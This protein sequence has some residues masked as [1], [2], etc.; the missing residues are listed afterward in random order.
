[1]SEIDLEKIKHVH[2][3]GIGGIGVSALARMFVHEGK[4][5]SGSDAAESKVTRDLEK[6]GVKVTIG[7][8]KENV[9]ADVDLVVYSPAVPPTNPEL[10]VAEE[11]GVQTLSY[12]EALGLISQNRYTIAVSGTHG[13]TTTTAMLADVLAELKPTVIVGS[14]LNKNQS[15]FAQGESEYF[16]VEACEYKRSF[17]NI[18]PNI[19]VITNIDA[20]HLDYYKD[21]ADI[22]GAFGEMAARVP[23]GGY[24]IADLSDESVR[25]AL[26]KVHVPVL[27][28]RTHFDPNLPLGVLGAHNRKN[29]AAA[30][31]VAHILGVSEIGACEA[32]KNFSG[33]WRRS[34]YK[35]TT[36]SGAIVL[37]D[38]AHHPAE[39]RAILA[40]FRERF[41]DKNLTVVFQPHLFSRTKQFLDEFA[42]VFADGANRVLVAPIYAARELPDPTVSSQMLAEAIRRAGGTAKALDSFEEIETLLLKTLEADDIL[43][44]MGAG[45]V[46]RIGE[47]LL[48]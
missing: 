11:R 25:C 15:N 45:D 9:P 35:G 14:L 46:Y 26:G 4:E 1:M 41:P 20:D 37:D 44:T 23:E 32:L 38:Y 17:L 28:Y 2:F 7:H 10:R 6:E 31:A 33:T 30:L 19:L 5:V 48:A 12:P 40:A 13:K 3:I 21:L 34:E 42:V 43:I 18:H 22:I 47:G 24:I 8:H 39:V 36:A 27:D 29:A 16:V